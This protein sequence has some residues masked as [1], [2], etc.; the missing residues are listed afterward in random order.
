MN[1]SS[2]IVSALLA[3]VAIQVGSA[4]S[5]AQGQAMTDET[6]WSGPVPDVPLLLD[7]TQH[8][9]MTRLSD[10]GDG[11][12]LL[13]PI[14]TRC[15]AVC[16][17]M[18]ERLQTAWAVTDPEGLRAKVLL[19][20]FDPQD[21]LEDLRRFRTLHRVPAAWKLAALEREEGLRFFASLGFR[22]MSLERRQFDHDG[23]LFILTHAGEVSAILGP[24]QLT[25]ERLRAEVD[26]AIH[27]PSLARRLG[28]HWIGFFG[29][30]M[31]LLGL[32]VSVYWDRLRTSP[33]SASR[34]ASER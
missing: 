20:S 3:A 6:S 24:E 27:G 19:V 15:R 1:V 28:T 18:A 2:R 4:V 14:F 13:M 26:A 21:T 7:S 12:I 32:V 31:V 17:L 33:H 23:K 8:R 9:T 11:P 5:V 30:G 25:T 16:S 10:L 29:V 34:G 22:W